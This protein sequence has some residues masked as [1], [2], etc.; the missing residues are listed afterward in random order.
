MFSLESMRVWGDTVKS[1]IIK[2]DQKKGTLL[3]NVLVRDELMV[4]F[5]KTLL[6]YIKST[7]QIKE[8]F[9]STCGHERLDNLIN[10]IKIKVM[11]CFNILV[12]FVFEVK[13]F[14]PVQGTKCYK[15]I[16]TLLPMVCTSIINFCKAPQMDLNEKLEVIYAT[17]S[18]YL[19]IIVSRIPHMKLL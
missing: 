11:R 2:L 16:P 9:I 15:L 6:I 4:V 7:N 18:L 8:C 12:T 10:E 1:F 14:L 13:S 5:T 3:E 19:F 17:D